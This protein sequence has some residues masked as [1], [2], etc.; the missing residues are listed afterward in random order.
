MEFIFIMTIV[1][2]GITLIVIVVIL[3]LAQ[4]FG[5]QNKINLAKDNFRNVMP[6]KAKAII[7]NIEKTALSTSQ[8]QQVKMQV[9]VMPEKG[10]NFV[11][12]IKELLTWSDF[13]ALKSGTIVS[14]FYNPVTMK[15]VTLIKA[16]I[17]T[18]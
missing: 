11:T 12:E 5:K 14:V 6:V 3:I 15:D 7:L 17:L 13:D 16:A 10:R 1:E 2:T 4:F 18:S 8:Q 9:Q